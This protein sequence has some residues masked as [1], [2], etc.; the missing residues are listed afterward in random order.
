[1][2]YPFI[3][4]FFIALLV[5]N[6]A[7]ATSAEKI[8][9]Y[10]KLQQI[11]IEYGN[12][13]DVCNQQKYDNKLSANSL[14]QLQKLPEET[15]RKGIMHLAEQ[16]YNRCLQPERGQLAERMLQLQSLALNENNLLEN[17][18]LITLKTLREL[19]FNISRA[20]AEILFYQL[21]AEQQAKLLAIPAL[22]RPFDALQY[23]EASSAIDHK[24]L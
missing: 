24:L 3:L 18:M 23:W 16:A 4:S 6:S 7:Y 10:K 8:L 14:K 11:N 1:M 2:P 22:Q 21:T 15:L 19:V 17:T 20:N 12:K 5:T 9:A 13:H